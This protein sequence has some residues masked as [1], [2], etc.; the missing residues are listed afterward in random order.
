[1]CVLRTHTEIVSFSRR[2]G[3]PLAGLTTLRRSPSGGGCSSPV[4]LLVQEILAFPISFGKD[5][6]STLTPRARN[7]NPS[8]SYLSALLPEIGRVG[9]PQDREASTRSLL[10][11]PDWVGFSLVPNPR[12]N[13]LPWV[14]QDVGLGS[15][16]L[17]QGWDRIPNRSFPH[18]RLQAG[19]GHLGWHLLKAVLPCLMLTEILGFPLSLGNRWLG[20]SPSFVILLE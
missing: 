19:E 6:E 17:T 13:P 20:N 2:D 14:V 8:H 5:G 3:Y 16:Y 9:P 1:M 15:V 7:G 11:S 10:Q 18:P 4:L 12:G